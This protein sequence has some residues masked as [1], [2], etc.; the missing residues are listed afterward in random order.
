MSQLQNLTID[1]KSSLFP[2]R[3]ECCSG[4]KQ[5]TNSAVGFITARDKM[6][7]HQMLSFKLDLRPLAKKKFKDQGAELSAQHKM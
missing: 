1:R 4:Y 7:H 3:A 5:I 6:R 2:L